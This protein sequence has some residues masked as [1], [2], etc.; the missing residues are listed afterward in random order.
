MTI[1]MIVTFA[2]AVLLLV[3][4]HFVA[5]LGQVKKEYCD[6]LE[7]LKEDPENS[8]LQEKVL[9][10][11][12]QYASRLRA[13]GLGSVFNEVALRKD[14]RAA[15]AEAESEVDAEAGNS[16]PSVKK[17]L[18]KLDGLRKKNLVTDAEY[19][20]RRRKILKDRTTE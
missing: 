15:T 4:I 17:R 14:I 10:L 5:R 11:G 1:G 3:L 16:Q 20:Q 6:S 19:Q 9:A 8:D 12:R 18:A 2:V 7:Q 13:V